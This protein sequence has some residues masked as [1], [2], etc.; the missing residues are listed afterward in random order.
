MRGLRSAQVA[1]LT[2]GLV[3]ACSGGGGSGSSGS[4]GGSTDL[5]SFLTQ[6]CGM[7]S[8][9]CGQL[10]KQYDQQKCRLFF[11]VA[12]A[13]TT[14]DPAKGQQCL[15][16]IQADA[17]NP[18]FCD[19]A[20]SSSPACNGVFASSASGTKNPGE[21]CSQDH[22]CA[23]GPPGSDVTC[24]G[25]SVNGATVRS[26]LVEA[27][28]KEGDACVG[29]K[30]GNVTSTSFGSGAI[31]PTVNICWTDD[32]LYCDGQSKKCVRTQDVDGPCT[33]TDTH[34]WVT[35]AYCDNTTK[36]CVARRPVGA[37]CPSGNECVAQTAY[38]D[39][40]TKKCMAS[41]PLGGTCTQSQECETE[42]CVNQKCATS[43]LSGVSI[44]VCD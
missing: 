29:T 36:K 42:S 38:C 8:G 9:C 41:V 18:V 43:T 34:S 35:T 25:T 24:E 27:R 31:P 44:F 2:A 21:P 19:G 23:A 14:Y 12:T 4:T 20:S 26:C 33:T 5:D 28:G 15:D 17:P 11:T 16:A 40:S 13:Q 30:S 32:S 22:D 3:V 37:D 7:Y 10:G 6:I 39:P 1:V